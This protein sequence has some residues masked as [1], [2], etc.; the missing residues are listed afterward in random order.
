[1]STTGLPRRRRHQP[2][3][4]YVPPPPTTRSGGR[5]TARS[6]RARSF[7][8]SSTATAAD[9]NSNSITAR[10]SSCDINLSLQLAR[11]QSTT[12]D[13]RVRLKPREPLKRN[14]EFDYRRRR[15]P[16]YSGAMGEDGGDDD[17]DDPEASDML[18]WMQRDAEGDVWG[19][20]EGSGDAAL[21]NV[22]PLPTDQAEIATRVP[23]FVDTSTVDW[24]RPPRQ[25]HCA[26]TDIIGNPL[27]PLPVGRPRHL[28]SDSTYLHRVQALVRRHRA[29]PKKASA[30]SLP[31]VLLPM[32]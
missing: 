9:N 25:N 3:A 11:P 32:A 27:G 1:M 12:L 18:V 2:P 16:E 28:I 29:P 26:F 15:R 7:T 24:T 30:S 6:S 14:Q 4:R 22:L 17:D 19:P 10:N 5:S 13:F 31:C 8:G 20:P 23:A 21:P